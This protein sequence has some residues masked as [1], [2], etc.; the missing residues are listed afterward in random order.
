[1]RKMAKKGAPKGNQNARK[2]GFYSRALT[3]AEKVE[4]EEASL[5][6]GIDQEIALLRVRLRELA[7]NEPDRLELHLEA[8]NTIARLIRTRYQISREQKK[9]LKEAIQKVLTD[10]AVPLGIGIAIGAR[11]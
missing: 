6:E 3:E 10:V 5:V 2:H 11:K 9:S 7:Q 1:M 4:L 8:A